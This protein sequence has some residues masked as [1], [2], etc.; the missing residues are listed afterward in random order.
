[1]RAILVPALVAAC[2]G[3]ASAG[4][5]GFAAKPSAAKNGDRVKIGFAAAAPTDCEVAVLDAK[6]AVVRH[7]V[8]GMLGEKPPAPLKPGLAQELEW[9]GKDD[10]GKPAAGGPFKVRVGLGMKPELHKMIGDNPGGLGYVNSLAVGPDG[11]LY[12]FHSFG[13]LHP[14]DAT[15]VCQAYDR[16]GKY[17]RQIIPYPANLPE[18]KLKGL[19]RLE[20]S[21]GVRVPFFYQAETRSMVPGLG[22]LPQHR[23]V[24]TRDGRL[25]FVGHQ[26]V[27]YRTR[28]NIAGKSQVV[29]VHTDGSVPPGGVLRT[30]LAEASSGGINLALSPDEKTVYAAG[31]PKGK[32]AAGTV[33]KFGWDDEKP[34][35]FVK[36]NLNDPR[37]VATDKEGNVY[38]A[39]RGGNRVAV[40][41]PD[42]ELLGELKVDRPAQVEVHPKTGAVYTLGGQYCQEL[43]KFTSW[44]EAVPAA[45]AAVKCYKQD[46]YWQL[47]AL[48]GSADPPVVWIGTSSNWTGFKLL[49]LEDRGNSFSDAV[50]VDK[51]PGNAK[52]NAGPRRKYNLYTA[53]SIHG[54]ALDRNN[55]QLLLNKRRY[56]IGTGEWSEGLEVADGC[57]EGT[58]SYGLDGNYYGLVQVWGNIL[59]RYSPQGKPLP[60]PE[61]AAKSGGIL[62]GPGSNFRLRGRGVT[63]DPAGNIYV[64]HQKDAA[65]NK[66]GDAGDANNLRV[67]GP[68]G[69]LKNPALI[70]SALRGLN[71]PRLDCRGNVYL[72]IGVR[73]SGKTVPDCF[74]GQALGQT[75]DN[76]KT[77]NT[78]EFNWYPFLY[79]CI[80]KFGPEGGEVR[81]G[82]GGTPMDYSI[83]KKTE[84]KGARW[85]HFGASPVLSWRQGF[86]DTCMCES[87]VFDVDGYGRSFYPDV[88]RFRVGVLDTDG[89]P[90]GTFGSYGN[91]DS[92]GPGSAVPIPEIPFCFPYLVAA[93][94]GF[95]YVGDRLN[96]RVVAVKFEH[97]AE[98]SCEVR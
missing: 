28:Y 50:D 82:C 66:P 83:G 26:E 61:S 35:A 41:K 21:P 73:P 53:G 98:E 39:D 57:K 4:E 10:A 90:I 92:A 80:V 91:Q 64:L 97:A 59:V 49:R 3:L 55:R 33:Y 68:D 32:T 22:D 42:G 44:K 85:I 13:D 16:S 95:V 86:P 2:A 17:L 78:N 8:A 31:M 20:V 96:R 43:R 7:L 87:P 77:L 76:K 71:S 5:V 89:N 79:G 30:V 54:M 1:M 12:V 9:D 14:G 19:K 67:L 18:E 58:G 81:S 29:L 47:M 46:G 23:A 75:Y 34:A 6:G 56:D 65:D 37:S 60:F 88:G 24:A 15:T 74:E 93:E 62:P 63:A 52:P 40:F 70:D 45:S 11:T 27:G 25:A 48:D 38:V 94:D 72:A 36:D 51:L 84:I 69:K